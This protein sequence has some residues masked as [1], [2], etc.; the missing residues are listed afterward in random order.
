ML[1]AFISLS[2]ANSFAADQ[3]DVTLLK[4]K[5]G[6]SVEIKGNK[7]SAIPGF[8]EVQINGQIL[9]LSRDG[10]KIISGDLYD[11]KGNFSYTERSNKK[12]V[13][14]AMGSIAEK[15]K[16]IYPAKNEKYTVSV[17][18]DISCPYC[19]KLH[20]H[21]KEF[22]D[23]GI[24]VEYLAYPRAGLGSKSAKN[25]QK[26]WCAEDRAAAM[27]EAKLNHTLPSK[28]CAGTEVA[29]Q[30][31]FGNEIGIQA[32]PTIVFSN[33]I[34]QPGYVEPDDL[35]QHLQSIAQ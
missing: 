35:L 28:S 34:I 5:L 31:L 15:D 10:E 25:M 17:F 7:P 2:V 16:I 23:M 6:P 9:Y 32:T 4:K 3:A 20:K 12:I 13:E 30:Y 1:S 29:E 22:N 26:I 11:L 24:T 19:S 8:Y 27:D 21:I 14:K 18:T 33:G